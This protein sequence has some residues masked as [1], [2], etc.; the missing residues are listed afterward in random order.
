MWKPLE[1]LARHIVD[2]R[3]RHRRRRKKYNATIRDAQERVV[4]RGS[5]K[6]ISRGGA[7][8]EG[9]PMS[10]GLLEGQK[11]LVDFL[12]LPADH[13]MRAQ[14]ATFPGWVSRVEESGDQFVAAVKFEHPVAD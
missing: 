8:L 7:K 6:D 12:L 9:L 1:T 14:W 4:F 2:D 13:E 5:V 10:H 11:V 3:R